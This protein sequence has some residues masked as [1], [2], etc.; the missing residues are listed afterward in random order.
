MDYN[1]DV[2]DG[3][4]SI[5]TNMRRR[6]LLLAAMGAVVVAASVVMIMKGPVP[7]DAAYH[8]FAD[9]R[10]LLGVPSFWNVASN[11]AFLWV[12]IAGLRE[13]LR[14]GRG[15]LPSMRWAY[16]AYFV[17]V[18]AVS[19]GSGYYH[20]APSTETLVWD[21]VPMAF[22]F[23]TFVGIVWAEHVDERVGRR[24]IAP[25]IALGVF[26]VWYWY[27]TE[28]LGRGDLRLYALVQFL[29][30]AVVAMLLL[31]FPSR[32]DGVGYLWMMFA[33][34]ALAK[35]VEHYDFAI[36]EALGRQM[37][38]HALKHLAAAAGLYGLVLALRHR[39]P[40]SA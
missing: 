18:A 40:R 26:S 39:T 28:T 32:L 10:T 1:R 27:Y 15:G 12:A 2:S 20:A 35:L 9:Q 17:G 4:P 3:G 36:Y 8:A 38:G 24:M 14:G 5:A 37:A 30:L 23:M 29:T 33:G 13:V 11:L 19:L 16:G 25:L 21:R 34:Y 31:F 7:Q 6:N 22:S